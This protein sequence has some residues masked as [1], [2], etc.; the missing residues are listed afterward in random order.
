MNAEMDERKAAVID[1]LAAK[2]QALMDLEAAQ[3]LASDVSP[4]DTTFE[5]LRKWVDPAAE[6]AHALL[7]S[8][9][10]VRAGRLA[11]AY[12]ALDKAAS[13]EDKPAPRDVLELRAGLLSK[14]GWEHWKSYEEGKIRKS[15]PPAYP[16]F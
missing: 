6:S 11:A 8:K 7:L 3:N 15:F 9:K 13:A 14:L 1:A 10:E 2:C 5:E 4:F 12:K 16:P